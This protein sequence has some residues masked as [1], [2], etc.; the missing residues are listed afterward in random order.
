MLDSDIDSLGVAVAEE[1]PLRDAPSPIAPLSSE[2]PSDL[3]P[4]IPPSL[5][6]RMSRD[7]AALR[8]TWATLE[9]SVRSPIDSHAWIESALATIANQT[10]PKLISVRDA[11]QCVAI[12]SLVSVRERGITRLVIPGAAQLGEPSDFVARSARSR[13]ALI[14]Q[15]LSLR[16]PA[17][18]H[19]LFDDSP[20]IAT[21]NE[22]AEGRALVVVRPQASA[23]FI[24]LDAS[25]LEPE[26]HLNSGRRSDLRRAARKAEQLGPTTIEILSPTPSEIAPLLDDAIAIEAQSW[27]GKA[28]TAL[29]ADPRRAMFFRHYARA[30]AASGILRICFFKVGDQRIAMQIA[31]EQCQGFWL[32]KV[33]YDERFS[34]TSPGQLLMR[35]TIAHAAQKGLER[36]EFLGKAESWTEVWT[37]EVRGCVSLRIYPR[38]PLGMAAFAIDGAASKLGRRVAR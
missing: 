37:K 26:K 16:A 11:D 22:M 8:G 3:P 12:G 1:P 21:V 17:H 4:S 15:L 18:L 38:T 25:W 32:L 31:V 5:V 29:A 10:R 2:L 6:V 30:A 27:K 35:A 24:P 13:A 28:G 33:G 14:D 36:Y 23:P 9:A 34:Q 7:V 19:R 20:T